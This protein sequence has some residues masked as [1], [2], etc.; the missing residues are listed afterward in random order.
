MGKKKS[1]G[2]GGLGSVFLTIVRILVFLFLIA[3]FCYNGKPLWRSVIPS[4]EHAVEKSGKVIRKETE[5]AVKFVSETADDA[6]KAA[7]NAVEETK[8]AAEETKDSIKGKASEIS[9]ED[10]K[11]LEELI[12][13]NIKK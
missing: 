4:A 6:K 3:N 2:N 10:E 11:E 7:G 13:K 5:K 1:S 9:E 8:K 12:E